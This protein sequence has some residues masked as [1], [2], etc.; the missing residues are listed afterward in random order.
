MPVG[1]GLAIELGVM[2]H[3][4]GSVAAGTPSSIGDIVDVGGLLG[5]AQDERSRNRGKTVRFIA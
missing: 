4:G 1:D 2:V 5:G 3:A